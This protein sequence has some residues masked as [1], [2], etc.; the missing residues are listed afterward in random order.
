MVSSWKRSGAL[1]VL[2]GLIVGGSAAAEPTTQQQMMYF[3]AYVQ[4]AP[5]CTAT[6]VDGEVR[7][8]GVSA[9][10][11]CPD[12]VAWAGW[13]TSIRDGFWTW[14]Q[15][16][17]TWPENPLPLCAEA[18]Q[19]NCCDPSVLDQATPI[20]GAPNEQCPYSPA[21]W[22]DNNHPLLYCSIMH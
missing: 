8:A 19:A 18:G 1:A 6:M 9:P 5:G 15:D 13:L 4:D 10:A 20:A 2:L 21:D 11:T 14:A 12:T 16:P 3:R 22:T 7:F 17:T